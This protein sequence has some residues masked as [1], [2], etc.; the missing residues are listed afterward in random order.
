MVFW[1][2]NN[3]AR[4]RFHETTKVS[5]SARI[6]DD[7]Q[8]GKYCYVGNYSDITKATIGNYVSIANN[9]SIG[10]GEHHLTNISTSSLFYD[11]P[12]EE[13]TQG[14]CSLGSDAWVGVDAIIRRGVSIGIGGV[15]GANSFVN[16]DVPDFG[17]VVGSPA[18]L[19]GFR[20]S[21]A[22]REAILKSQWWE[23]DLERART[24]MKQL[25]VNMFA[26]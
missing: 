20:F 1:R 4:K 14:D 17:I 19:I 15:V 13:L 8:L 10:S 23:E 9:V 22:Q 16:A 12:Y 26:V 18:R 5:A 24:I 6:S 21:E 7:T 11:D 25:K 3:N 2:S